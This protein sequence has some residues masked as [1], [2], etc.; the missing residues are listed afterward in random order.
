MVAIYVDGEDKTRQISDWEIWPGKQGELMLTCH[1]PSGKKFTRP[2]ANCEV[3]PTEVVQGK[4]MSKKGSAVFGAV[5]TASIYG[6]KY[7][8]LRY[9]G[10]D[11]LHLIKADDLVFTAEASFK[12]EA[13]FNYFVDVAKA[14]I[15]HA[16]EQSKP[17]AESVLRQLES[18]PAHEDSALQAYC[19][20]A[21]R[22]RVPGDGFVYPFGVNQSQLKA[23]EQAFSA[24]VSVIEGPPGTGKTQTILNI[25]ANIVLRGQTVAILSNNNPAVANVYEKLDKA[26]LGYLAARLGSKQNRVDFFEALP[27]PPTGSPAPAPTMERLQATLQ[28][29]QQYLHAQD[30]AARLQAQIDELRIEQRYLRQWGQQNVPTPP[31]A[32][33][34]YQLTPEKSTDLMAY[35]SYLA[36]RPIRF[37]DR[38]ALWLKFGMLRLKSFDSPDK[39]RSATHAL[40]RHFYE[41]ALAEKEAALAA[42]RHTLARG[43]FDG[44]MTELS[45]GSM[46]YLKAH[47]HQQISAD[48]EFE[49][50]SYRQQFDA[51]VRR[52]PVMGSSTFSIVNSIGRGALLDYVILDEASQQD[53]VPGILALG[54]ARNLIIVGDRKQLPH[55]PAHL[56]IPAPSAAYDCD[57]YSLLDSCLRAFRQPVP[58]T[59]L[60]EHYRCHPRIIQFCNQQFYDNQLVPM[61]RDDG[62]Q[63]L[64]LLVTA[65]GNHRRGNANLRELDTVMQALKSDGDTGWDAQ[66]SRGFIAPYNAQVQLSRQ[67]LPEN[68]VKD[69]VHKFQGRE[70][71]EIVFSTVLDKRSGQR[72]IDFVDDPHLI[73]VAVSRAKNKFTLVT[74]DEVFAANNGHIAA[75]VRYM[76]YYADPQQVR[77]AIVV[78]AFDLLYKEY[79]AS[80]LRLNARL[81]PHDS[82]FKSEQIVAQ[83][84]RELLSGDDFCGLTA[85][86]QVL[87]MQLVSP[88]NGDWSARELEFMRNHASCDVVVYYKVGKAPLGVIEIDGGGHATAAQSERDALKDAILQKSGLRLLRLK[89]VESHIEEK[90]E[91]FLGQWTSP[92][93]I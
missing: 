33:E 77:R 73:N 28:E 36:G 50:G 88:I 58:V 5:D 22:E 43:D 29:L 69:T 87:L 41:K 84:L 54:C 76:E 46:A 19:S 38:V 2:L 67:Q 23:V 65:R 16:A 80:L 79:D 74:G 40:Q 68:F 26:G 4:L 48:A 47:L 59:L 91:G 85:H 62:E 78:S 18:L 53:I 32:L 6:H 39:R 93:Q 35:F 20:G 34:K 10:E 71:E 57:R 51:F 37:R 82:Q 49:E 13:V 61:M 72:G 52:F 21:Q 92:S 56:H 81:R 70:C 45:G 64:Q 89:T 27:L 1:F 11:K 55:I 66:A 42:H 25:I 90:I 12:G 8:A 75:L 9:R 86:S 63:S 44:L 24:Q 30:A 14:R 3:R 7:A 17:I 31:M 60:K 83:I 15:A